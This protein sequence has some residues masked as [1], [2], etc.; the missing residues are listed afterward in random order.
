MDARKGRG[1]SCDLFEKILAERDGLSREDVV[2]HQEE[3]PFSIRR[4]SAVSTIS[5]GRSKTA[6]ATPGTAGLRKRKQILSAGSRAQDAEKWRYLTTDASS[7]P[8]GRSRPPGR[9]GGMPPAV[10][11]SVSPLAR[12]LRHRSFSRPRGACAASTASPPAVACGRGGVAGTA[13]SGRAP[14]PP[15]ERYRASYPPR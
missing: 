9:T 12:P 11:A 13:T 2:R 8:P 7:G 6:R 5:F 15:P 1:R 4:R 3:C 10:L 14:L